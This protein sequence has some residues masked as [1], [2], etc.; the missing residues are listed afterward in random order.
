VFAWEVL[1]LGT[2]NGTRGL[3]LLHRKAQAFPRVIRY[4]ARLW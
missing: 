4:A 2:W 3:R 1:P